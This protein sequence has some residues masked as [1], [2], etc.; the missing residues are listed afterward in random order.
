MTSL[1]RKN[2]SWEESVG[3]WYLRRAAEGLVAQVAKTRPNGGA[4]AVARLH[5]SQKNEGK[6]P[7]PAALGRSLN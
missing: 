5:D 4:V 6:C 7:K 2:A 3:N 1:P